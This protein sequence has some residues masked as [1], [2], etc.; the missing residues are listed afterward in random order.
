MSDYRLT[1]VKGGERLA[2]EIVD[3]GYKTEFE[4]EMAWIS[5]VEDDFLSGLWTLWE[6]DQL[7]KDGYKNYLD[8]WDRR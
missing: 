1:Y 3:A 2:R 6:R 4:R 7:L 5:Q 8:R